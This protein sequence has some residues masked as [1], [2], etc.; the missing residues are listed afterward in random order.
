MADNLYTRAKTSV[1][2][3]ELKGYSVWGYGDEPAHAGTEPAASVDLCMG[4]DLPQEIC[5]KKCASK[6]YGE[7]LVFIEKWK[8][9]QKKRES[10]YR[11]KGNTDNP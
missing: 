4:C 2:R 3:G 11:K 5:D 9:K 7:R 6:S 1:N 8:E 10:R